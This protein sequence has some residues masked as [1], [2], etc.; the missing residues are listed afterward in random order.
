MAEWKIE[1]VYSVSG[2]TIVE[3][4][5]RDEVEEMILAEDFPDIYGEEMVRGYDIISVERVGAD[6]VMQMLDMDGDK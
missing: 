4:D 2:Y 6:N 5:T 1:I 3:A